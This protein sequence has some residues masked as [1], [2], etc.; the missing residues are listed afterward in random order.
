MSAPGICA[1]AEDYNPRHDRAFAETWLTY[2]IMHSG[3]FCRASDLWEPQDAYQRAVLR[4]RAHEVV[5]KAKRLGWHI[6]SS[7]ECG[8]RVTGAH[9]P[10]YLHLHERAEDRAEGEAV[11]QLTLAE[12]GVVE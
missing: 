7:R 1:V 2:L 10:A 9:I 6:E 11:G 5:Q 8:Y 12:C 3:Q 4:Q